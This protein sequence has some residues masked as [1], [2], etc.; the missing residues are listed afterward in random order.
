MARAAVDTKKGTQNGK[1]Q[2]DLV[3]E[4]RRQKRQNKH[5]RRIIFLVGVLF[6]LAYLSGLL[7]AV[8]A[9]GNV[10]YESAT[11]A[12]A[13][14]AGYPVQTG[15]STIDQVELLSGGFVALGAEGCM[16]YSSGGNRL[17]SIQTGYLR[18]AIAAGNTR[19]LLYQRAGTELRIESRTKTIY[20][21]TY[22]NNIL[23]ASMSENG[24]FAVVTESDH[25]LVS[26]TMYSASMAELLTYSMTDSE[27]IPARMAYAEDN[28]TLAVATIS[29]SGGQMQAQLYLISSATGTV[30]LIAR[31]Q[32]TPMAIE[33]I[34]KTQVLVL[35]DSKAVLYD[36]QTQAELAQY[37]YQNKTLVNYA[38][39]DGQLALLLSQGMQGEVVLLQDELEEVADISIDSVANQIALDAEQIYLVYEKAVESYAQDGTLLETQSSDQKITSLVVAD[40]I[41][42]FTI[43][44][45]TVFTPPTL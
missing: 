10:W 26:L 20:T 30:E 23:L 43:N 11:I 34:S 5:R 33:W 13:K 41:L 15:L 3:Q 38:V 9:Q 17:R 37:D 36:V 28:K 31:E 44:E 19:Y 7:S 14:Q 12:F 4:M 35:Y 29:A 21:K 32:A 6:L 24:S 22:A 45:T 16:V 8:V 18:P 42:L 1:K 27:G 2:V 40:E 25:Y 39:Y